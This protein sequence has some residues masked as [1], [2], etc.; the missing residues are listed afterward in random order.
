MADVAS[1][2]AGRDEAIRL[3][4]AQILAWGGTYYLPALLAAPIAAD[5]GIRVAAVFWA[6]SG[7]L[8]LS[9]LLGP[10]IGR[11]IDRQCGRTALAV[12]AGVI[13]AGLVVL[14]GAQGPVTLWIAWGLLGIG[15]A[16]GLYEAAFAVLAA[17]YGEG[18]RRPITTLTLIAGFASLIAWPLTG[19]AE[20]LVGWR[21]T[22]L[23]WAGLMLAV[24]LPLYL[25]LP[26][27]HPPPEE[28]AEET[29]PV[30]GS[31]TMTL[32]AAAFA[33]GW[34]VSSAMAAHL[35]LLLQSAGATPAAAIAAAA[36]VGPAQVA[37]R[38]AEA[39]LAKRL[40]PLVSARAAYLA[41]PIGAALVAAGGPPAALPLLH[42]LGNGVAT[43][44]RGTVPLALFGPQ[45]YGLRQGR[46]A[47]PARI[48]AALAP[49]L[50][51]LA[52]ARW[53]AGALWL[54]A[55]LSLTAAALLCLVRTKA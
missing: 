33:L 10:G 16:A 23:I 9:A 42:G 54:S 51:A 46:L 8:V 34:F 17:Q 2:R 50:F 5:L 45:D 14:A 28:P 44:A 38:L 36:L 1:S 6:F 35:P 13:A 21:I 19:I 41:H 12:S 29:A 31:R 43:I 25:T 40:H 22:C 49:A 30:E 32:L 37:G 24:A 48:A 15:M 52:M 20:A 11:W 4:I 47:A 7:A 53:G 18:A 26:S 39:A 55:G 3:G 27:G